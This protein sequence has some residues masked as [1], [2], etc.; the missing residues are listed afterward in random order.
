MARQTSLMQTLQCARSK[1]NMSTTLGE[2]IR[3]TLKALSIKASAGSSQGV[4]HHQ[5]SRQAELQLTWPPDRSCRVS[6]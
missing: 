4:L 6:S 5:S 2:G 1:G 3:R